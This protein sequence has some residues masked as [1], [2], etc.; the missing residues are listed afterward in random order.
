MKK[1]LLGLTTTPGSDWREKIEEINKFNI[2]EIALFP[3]YL[4]LPD[5]KIL[6]NLLDKSKVKSI[7]HVHIREDFEIEE[8]D[9]LVKKYN[10]KVF[11][12][13]CDQKGL[14]AFNKCKK[15][16]KLSY[17]ENQRIDNPDVFERYLGLSGGICV[18]FSHLDDNI[19]TSKRNVKFINEWMK[20]YPIG[21]C[22]VSAIRRILFWSHSYHKFKKLSDLDYIIKYKE[23]LPELISLELENSFEEQIKAREYLKSKSL[24]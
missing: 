23:Y 11:N 13:H 6:Y 8:I 10:V 3:T 19:F 16:Q 21:C 20:K 17:F 7:P 1:I 15:Y 22:H 18:D 24:I 5:R 12:I 4:K 14:D 2:E 9:Y